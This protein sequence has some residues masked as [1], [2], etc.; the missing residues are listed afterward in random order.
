[1]SDKRGKWWDGG[2]I[3]YSDD[4]K[5]V[6]IWSGMVWVGI[7]LLGSLSL[8]IFGSEEAFNLDE[9]WFVA[10]QISIL[11]ILVILGVFLT[12]ST[13]FLVDRERNQY[14]LITRWL[15]YTSKKETGTLDQIEALIVRERKQ[16]NA[17]V[18]ASYLHLYLKLADQELYLF[19]ISNWLT[20]DE[21]RQLSNFLNIPLIFTDG[22]P[23]PSKGNYWRVEN[24]DKKT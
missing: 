17:D 10:L 9:P 15:F 7:A 16:E 5:H 12:Q 21:A 11:L 4:G 1:M 20:T 24:N 14:Q 13:T 6:S 18:S 23:P 22:F 19:Q 3:T 8:M 2:T